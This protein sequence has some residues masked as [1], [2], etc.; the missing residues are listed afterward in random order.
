ME[1]DTRDVPCD[2]VSTSMWYAIVVIYVV[3]QFTCV[4]V[5]HCPEWAPVEMLEVTDDDTTPI[6]ATW[7]MYNAQKGGLRYSTAV[8]LSGRGVLLS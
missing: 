1:F 5:E 7:D 2:A 4:E 6:C 8:A 3:C